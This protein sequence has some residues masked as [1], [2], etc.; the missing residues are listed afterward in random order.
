MSMTNILLVDDDFEDQMFFRT[1]LEQINWETKCS[2][3]NNG[4]D[5]LRLV[6]DEQPDII[7]LDLNMPLM[8]G[9]EFM[10]QFRQ[11]DKETPV[12]IFTTSEDDKDISEA[13]KCGAQGFFTKPSG[14][15]KLKEVLT[16]ILDSDIRSYKGFI[17]IY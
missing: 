6:E 10:Q 5:A 16:D 7:F 1:A 9:F 3:A 15:V 4:I 11:L 2:F 8:N 13:H 17:R 14:Y 12:V